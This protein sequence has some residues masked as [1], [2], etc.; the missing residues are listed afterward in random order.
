VLEGGLLGGEVAAGLDRA[1]EPRVEGLD[2]VV[3]MMAL[4]S[5]SKARNGTNSGQAFSQS[6]MIA[7]YCFSQ[8]PLNSANASRA[9][10]SDAAV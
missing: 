9:A 1:A 10:A 4:I 2:R 3:Q 7:G 5:R 8:V 6:R